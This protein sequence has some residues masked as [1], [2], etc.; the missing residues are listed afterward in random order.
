MNK[1]S[2]TIVRCQISK[3]KDLSKILSLGYLPPVNDYRPINS[4]NNEEIFFP[5]ELLY[6]KSSKLVQLSTIVNKEIIFPKEYPYTSSTTKI[7]RVNF[8]EL[9]EECLKIIGLNKKDLVIDI[10]SNDGNLLS[11]FKNNHRVLGVTPELIGKIAIKKGIDTLIKYF[12]NSTSKLILKKYGK[13]KLIT[14]TNVFAHIDD[15]HQVIKNIVKILDKDGVFVSESHYFVSLIKTVQYDTIYHEHMRYYSLTSLHYLF[16]KYGL[17]IFHAK[18][19]PTHGGS[20]RVYVS[21]SNKYRVRSSVKKILSSEKKYLT[22]SKFEKFKNDVIKSKISLYALLKKIKSQ[23]KLVFGVGA[24]SRAATL[25][26]YVGLNEDIIK[27]ILEIKGSYKIGKYMPGTN[28]PII[29]ENF[30]KKEKPD[31]LLLLSWHIS[32][33]LIKNFKKKGFKGKFI[34]PLPVP[35]IVK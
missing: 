25:V 19:I 31:Y 5:A 28:I 32:K 16:K 11:N 26:N 8:K 9:Y 4:I 35:R 14:A 22:F 23:N 30:I 33:S 2:K 12:D 6:S 15:I 17:K 21:K 18:E 24:P 34:L 10:G 1:K 3:K 29:D 7:L 20:I 27:Y 13:A